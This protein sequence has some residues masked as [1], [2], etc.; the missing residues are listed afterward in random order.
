[1]QYVSSSSPLSFQLVFFIIHS[2]EYLAFKSSPCPVLSEKPEP[3][4]ILPDQVQ[5][6]LFQADAIFKSFQG[7]GLVSHVVHYGYSRYQSITGYTTFHYATLLR[8]YCGLVLCFWV[9]RGL[10]QA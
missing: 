10:G 3:S 9:F 1:M 6:S 5:R 7:G 8:I 4:W 2:Q